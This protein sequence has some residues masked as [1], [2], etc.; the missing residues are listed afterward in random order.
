MDRLRGNSVTPTRRVRLY[1]GRAVHKVR[2]MDDGIGYFTTCA[3]FLTAE[4]ENHWLPDDT[5]ITCRRC[6]RDEVKHGTEA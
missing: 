6:I 3:L 5:Q 2:P 1:G 4:A